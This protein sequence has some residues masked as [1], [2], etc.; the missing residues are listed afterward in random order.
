MTDKAASTSENFHGHQPRECGEHRTVGQVRAWCFDCGEW[1]YARP[2]M[3]CRG[4]ELPRLRGAL[5]YIG[6]PTMGRPPDCDPVTHVSH[7]DERE[8]RR[9]L[10][11]CIQMAQQALPSGDY[12]K[13]EK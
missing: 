5:T 1:C 12:A 3:A 4:C 8:V 10:M 13:E 2:E 11:A 6:S 9:T 7:M